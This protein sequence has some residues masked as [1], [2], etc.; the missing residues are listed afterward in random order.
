MANQFEFKLPNGQ[1]VYTGNQ[2]PETMPLSFKEYPETSIRSIDDIAEIVKND[3]RATSREKMRNYI[4]NQGR[5]SS[6]N[7]YMAAWML[8]RVIFNQ[9]G[10]WHDLAPEFLYM[11]INGGKDNGSMLDDG[12]VKVTDEGI[13]QRTYIP[14][15]AYQQRTIGMEQWRMATQNAKNY[16]AY[17]CYQM[18]TSSMEKCYLAMLS[19]IAGRGCVGTAVHVGNNYMRSGITAGVDRGV[20]NHAV[21]GDDIVLKTPRPKSIEDFDIVSPQS[22]GKD[23][24][25]KGFTD[26]NYRHFQQTYKVHAFYGMRSAVATADQVSETRIR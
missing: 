18:P 9:T 6:C 4:R 19:C 14:Y 7:A 15:E 25:D 1:L 13:C 11:L 26:L 21:P 5:R 8:C 10:I 20:G 17:E 16:R 3:K 22:W 2:E 12:M 24:A 23:F